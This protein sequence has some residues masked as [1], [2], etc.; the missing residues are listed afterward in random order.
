MTHS[1]RMTTPYFGGLMR[2]D[3]ALLIT[4][5]GWGVLLLSLALLLRCALQTRLP[6]PA[7]TAWRE[8]GLL[9]RRNPAIATAS[10]AGVWRPEL[11]V[12]P[13]YWDNLKLKQ[14]GGWCCTMNGS[15]CCGAI[16]CASWCCTSSP[17]CISRCP[18]SGAG[19]RAMSWTASWRW[20]TPAAGAAG[21][22]SIARSVAGA[23]E[24][25]G[26]SSHGWLSALSQADLALRLRVLLAPR[27]CD[28]ALLSG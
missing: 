25:A 21:G 4:L 12:N 20:M 9:L 15:T 11:W 26:A 5:S 1:I 10:L 19:R 14:T 6:K 18:G 22:G 2:G 24:A 3:G 13:H 16:T 8:G 23:V 27:R 17:A 7:G 28:P